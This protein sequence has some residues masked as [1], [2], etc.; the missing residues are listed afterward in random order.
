MNPQVLA[1]T[2][3]EAHNFATTRWSLI[4]TSADLGADDQKAQ[5][6]LSELCR[7][8]WRPIF[9]FVCRRGHSTQDDIDGMFRCA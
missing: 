2:G 3:D 9:S 5:Q 4:L 1:E 7:L 8:Y 6:A